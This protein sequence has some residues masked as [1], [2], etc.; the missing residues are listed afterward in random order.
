MHELVRDRAFHMLLTEKVAGA[1]DD[2][3]WVW[4]EPACVRQVTGRADDVGARESAVG[5]REV[6]EEE[7]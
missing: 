4:H 5:E 7:D 6:F 2:G 1:E 3:A